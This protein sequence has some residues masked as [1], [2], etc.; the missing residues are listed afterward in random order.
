MRVVLIFES[1]IVKQVKMRNVCLEFQIN[2]SHVSYLT[3]I[4]VIPSNVFQ[5]KFKTTSCIHKFRVLFRRRVDEL[6]AKKNKH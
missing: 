4:S 1:L 2:W 5:Q 6:T 3:T